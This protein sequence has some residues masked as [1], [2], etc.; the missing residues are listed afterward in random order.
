MALKL[1][2]VLGYYDW[3]IE[4]CVMVCLELVGKARGGKAVVRIYI[5]IVLEWG[6]GEGVAGITFFSRLVAR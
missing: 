4:L 2:I 3:G 6:V 1:Q 5:G